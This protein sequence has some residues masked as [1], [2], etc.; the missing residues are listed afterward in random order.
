MVPL[1]D[2]TLRTLTARAAGKGPYA[3]DT[4]LSFA[5]PPDKEPLD[6]QLALGKRIYYNSCVYCH[7]VDGVGISVFLCAK[8]SIRKLGYSAEK[9]RDYIQQPEFPMT[10]LRLT[11]DEEKAV[12]AY[13]ARFMAEK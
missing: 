2:Q 13:V 7:G 12:A 10:R 5:M 1:L 8:T 9:I 11:P 4:P 3:S 6:P